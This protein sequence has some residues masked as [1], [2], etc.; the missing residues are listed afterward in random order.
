MFLSGYVKGDL[1]LVRV[2]Q[3][4]DLGGA[5]A[6]EDAAA[7]GHGLGTDNDH[8]DAALEA[9]DVGNGGLGDF[10]NGD[11]RLAELRTDAVALLG[12]VLVAD[13]DDL[14]GDA[15]GANDALLGSTAEEAGDGARGTRREDGRSVLD[16]LPPNV[17]DALA[18]LDG[19]GSEDGRVGEEVVAGRLKAAAPARLVILT[20]PQG[21]D[22]E[23][24]KEIGAGHEGHGVP[25][26][27]VED[28]DLGLDEVKRL[29]HGG[30]GLGVEELYEGLD[31]GDGLGIGGVRRE[32]VVVG[33]DDVEGGRGR[34]HRTEREVCRGGGLSGVLAGVRR[35]GVG[36]KGGA[37]WPVR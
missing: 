13:V 30:R 36:W 26:R 22:D 7:L 31:G 32:Q 27:G 6:G 21:L 16:E 25:D 3:L 15:A 8:G 5:E 23:A 11:A 37:K 34:G 2:G 10:G 33:G 20:L 14:E 12:A 17:G 4:G 35:H 1:G 28:G 9:H 19:A 18:G 24:L 29:E